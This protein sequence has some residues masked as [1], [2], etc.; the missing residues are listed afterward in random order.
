MQN[1]PVLMVVVVLQVEVRHL[2]MSEQQW[3]T[4]RW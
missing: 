3:A 2:D 4:E 1:T